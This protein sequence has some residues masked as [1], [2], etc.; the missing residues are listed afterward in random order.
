MNQKE[1]LEL[2]LQNINV[3]SVG[4]AA[5]GHLHTGIA[6]SNSSA[7]SK[8]LPCFQH[9]CL[10]YGTN[11]GWWVHHKVSC[12]SVFLCVCVRSPS[13]FWSSWPIFTE[14]GAETMPIETLKLSQFYTVDN[15]NEAVARSCQVRETVAPESWNTAMCDSRPLKYMQILNIISFMSSKATKYC[16]HNIC[17]LL[18]IWWP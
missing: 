10:S 9:T 16:L 14:R 18:S 1:T 5:S 13:K 6:V 15:N 11:V 12:M 7:K 17:T 8:F 3:D 4:L 2:F